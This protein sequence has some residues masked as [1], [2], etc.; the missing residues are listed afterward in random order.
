MSVFREDFDGELTIVPSGDPD[1]VCRDALQ[2]F[3]EMAAKGAKRVKIIV[4]TDKGPEVWVPYV[5]CIMEQ[6]LRVSVEVV[7]EGDVGG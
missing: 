7:T 1:K 4:K 3:L 2:K 5:K 6:N